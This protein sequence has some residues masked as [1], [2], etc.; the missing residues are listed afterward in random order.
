M[1][2]GRPQRGSQTA[3]RPSFLP[4]LT[5]VP[6]GAAFRRACWIG[7]EKAISFKYLTLSWVGRIGFIFV[8]F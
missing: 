8:F 3:A 2:I 7:R 6:G 1:Q 5:F 4:I